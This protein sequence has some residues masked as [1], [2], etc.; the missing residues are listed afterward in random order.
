M[1]DFRPKNHNDQRLF[2]FVE[3]REPAAGIGYSNGWLLNYIQN[4]YFTRKNTSSPTQV[5]LQV[6][7]HHS[8]TL[9]HVC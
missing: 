1:S 7:H 6:T 4:I 8:T 3:R 9:A 2:F 5:S